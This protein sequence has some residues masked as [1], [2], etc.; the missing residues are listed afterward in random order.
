MFKAEMIAP[1]GLNCSLCSLALREKDPCPGCNGPD[2]INRSSVQVC[3][4]SFAAAGEQRTVTDTVTNARIFHA[5]MLWKR[6]S[7]TRRS[8]R[9]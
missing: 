5:K 7:D 2:E 4:G 6:R 9:E 8:I 3:A 1:C